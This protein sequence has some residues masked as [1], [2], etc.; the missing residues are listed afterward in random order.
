MRIT[1]EGN[2][3]GVIGGLLILLISAIIVISL[4][5]DF[6]LEE[7]RASQNV[8]ILPSSW[9]HKR[10]TICTLMQNEVR[11]VRE[12]LDFHLKLGWNKIMIYDDG[13]T[14]G[15][16]E[17][18]RKNYPP[19]LVEVIEVSSMN[20]TKPNRRYGFTKL[21]EKA[22]PDCFQRNWNTSLALINL[23]VDEFI[24][25]NE[26]FW[27][28]TDPMWEAWKQADFFNTSESITVAYDLSEFGF[29]HHVTQPNGSV[30]SSYT[31]RIPMSSKEK[32]SFNLSKPLKQPTAG[33]VLYLPNGHV[34][35]IMPSV[36]YP[37]GGWRK[38]IRWKNFQVNHYRFRSYNGVKEKFLKN[39]YGKSLIHL[40]MDHPTFY[41]FNW[42]KD[43]N[44]I[45]FD[46]RWFKK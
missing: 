43:D 15:T 11:F 13:S 20:W 37:V 44:I 8:L 34:E 12:W 38:A 45:R 19:D 35:V 24:Y 22:F 6:R 28:E 1:N 46:H 32:A 16:P 39:L 9:K 26:A 40:P 3:R 14:D 30:I 23:D 31:R 21:Q 27:N 4:S 41:Y 36:H 7:V 2:R 18:I 33:K 29:D 17:L 10:R 42:V 5:F 25:P